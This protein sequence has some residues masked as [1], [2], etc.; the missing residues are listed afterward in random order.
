M[1][2]HPRPI[3]SLFPQTL[4]V[5]NQQAQAEPP[6]PTHEEGVLVVSLARLGLKGATG[7]SSTP[8]RRLCSLIHMETT[9]LPREQNRRPLSLKSTHR[10][11]IRGF[12]KSSRPM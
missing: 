4:A 9:A 2:H 10:T 11:T 8:P 12:R 7:S 3:M 1:A 5:D 6:F